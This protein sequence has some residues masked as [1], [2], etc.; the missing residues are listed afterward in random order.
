MTNRVTTQLADD[1]IP[2]KGGLFK[3]EEDDEDDG[4]MFGGNK[5]RKETF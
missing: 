2:S 1:R 3:I 5:G 4:F